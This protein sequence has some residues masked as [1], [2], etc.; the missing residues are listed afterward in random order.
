MTHAD[1]FGNGGLPNMRNWDYTV[2]G[3]RLANDERCLGAGLAAYFVKAVLDRGIPMHTGVNVQELIGD[4]ARVVGVRAEKDGKALFVK[5]GRGVVIAVSGYEKNAAHNKFL[6]QQLDME[7]MLFPSIDGVHFRLAGMFGARVARVPDVNMLG[8][9][10]PGEEL[11][12]GTAL[13]RGATA[14]LGVPHTIVVNRMG[15]RFADESFYRSISFALD[16]I[17]GG[18]QTHPNFPCWAIFDGQAREKYPFGSVMAG[19]DLPEGMAV[20]ADS[21]AELAAKTGVDGNGL[22]ATIATFNG[23]CA[24]GEDAE[25]QRGSH[26]WSVTMCGD[27][28]QKP[29]PTLG[30]LAKPPFY[31]VALR[32]LGSGGTAA[33]GLV[34]DHHARVIGWDDKPIEGLYAAGNS[35]ARLDSGAMLQ[36]GVSNARG[37]THGYLAALHA[38]GRPSDLLQKE[39]ARFGVGEFET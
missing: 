38:A 15:K 3:Q 14:F 30:T 17:D 35:V 8:I 7:S 23:Y 22:A 24:S 20:K 18:N 36:S 31:A 33:A 6:A 29:N 34:T 26:P 10:T 39:I 16:F 12:S 9:H 28:N 4:G 13:W 27:P 37:M 5:A 19:Q 1:M 2:M 21:I 25:F 32:R 11:E